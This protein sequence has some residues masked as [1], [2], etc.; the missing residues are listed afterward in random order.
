MVARGAAIERMTA[1]GLPRYQTSDLFAANGGEELVR[2][3]STATYRSRY[4]GGFVRYTW[5]DPMGPGRGGYWTAEYPD[6][7]VGYFGADSQGVIDPPSRL[8]SA[9]SHDRR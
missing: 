5:V 8:R 3:G 2:L 1:R 7:R 6:G 4:E 9:L